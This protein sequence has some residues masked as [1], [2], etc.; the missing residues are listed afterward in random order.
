M[1]QTMVSL[2]VSTR[3][4]QMNEADVTPW[5]D[6]RS[7]KEDASRLISKLLENDPVIQDIAIQGAVPSWQL[8]FD[9]LK[10]N[11]MVDE[12]TLDLGPIEDE[13]STLQD[14]LRMVE[15]FVEMLKVNTSIR[16]LRIP[17]VSNPGCRIALFEAL[18]SSDANRIGITRIVILDPDN[19]S[20][21]TCL[22]AR[23]CECLSRY[24]ASNQHLVKLEVG[25]Q[26]AE[27]AAILCHGLVRSS[28][29]T[30]GL[31]LSS[32][33]MNDPRGN[34]VHLLGA[35]LQ[36]CCKYNIAC[37]KLRFH[38]KT[39]G[40]SFK[41][42]FSEYLPL[43]LS[44][45]DIRLEFP[46]GRVPFVEHLGLGMKR[47]GGIERLLLQLYT[48]ETDL[49]EL[50]QGLGTV[51]HLSVHNID[52]SQRHARPV[53]EMSPDH[54]GSLLS[55]CTK[56]EQLV[57][58]DRDLSLDQLFVLRQ[59]IKL[60]PTLKSIEIKSADAVDARHSHDT[61]LVDIVRENCNIKAAHSCALS[62]YGSCLTSFHC[63]LN[64]VN[65]RILLGGRISLGLWPHIISKLGTDQGQGYLRNDAAGA[66]E[67]QQQ[68]PLQALYHLLRQQ[69]ELMMQGTTQRQK[70][71]KRR[72]P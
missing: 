42:L 47:H 41:I 39:G 22:N 2:T 60:L 30:L 24:L 14:L 46:L 48:S 65:A 20:G 21:G 69:P 66:D 67:R 62:C 36:P 17:G 18:A 1:S 61:T 70:G 38:L 27:S 12:I 72:R 63:L 10:K 23:E 52:W 54:L 58:M 31:E 11:S 16:T 53:S 33:D 57:I 40:S 68:I 55:S 7:T 19:S 8:L 49:R 29:T 13:A 4:N 9:A 34:W 32:Q 44:V 5:L 43:F 71:T 6:P 59:T 37:L 64:K 51:K 3:N 15:S 26:D 28:V 50:H 35:A 25:L 45:T 56:L